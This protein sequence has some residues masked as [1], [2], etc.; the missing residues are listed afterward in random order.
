MKKIFLQAIEL[1]D[2]VF[3]SEKD[4]LA[5]VDK[6]GSASNLIDKLIS[7]GKLV[8]SK[9]GDKG[10]SV[11]SKTDG[12]QMQAYS[13]NV[14]DTVGAGDIFDS[15]FLAAYVQEKE[16]DECLLWGSA[17]A[18]YSL[19]FSGASNSPNKL[20]LGNFISNNKIVIKKIY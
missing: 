9:A 10:A 20:Q 13:V 8:I 2:I 11:Y 18:A 12:Y 6:M 15:G 5:V 16:I 1:S 19:Q 3:G 4:E 7:E 14:V 17:A